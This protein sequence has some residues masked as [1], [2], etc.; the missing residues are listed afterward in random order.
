[1]PIATYIIFII[2]ALECLK[3]CA[4]LLSLNGIYLVRTIIFVF[5]NNKQYL[6]ESKLW[7]TKSCQT[8]CCS[9]L[10]PTYILNKKIKKKKCRTKRIVSP[11]HY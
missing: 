6:K 4:N 11:L 7:T 2:L 9:H 5:I 1:M 3:K 10:V 8:L